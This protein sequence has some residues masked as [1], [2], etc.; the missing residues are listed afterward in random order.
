MVL[1]IDEHRGEQG[2][3]PICEQLPIASV[4]VP[5]DEGT[6]ARPFPASGSCC[7]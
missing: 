7:S 1:F 2:F 5:R 6:R 4:D 3:E